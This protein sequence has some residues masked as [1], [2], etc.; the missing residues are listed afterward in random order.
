MKVKIPNYGWPMASAEEHYGGKMKETK[1]NMRNT[2]Y[3]N[4]IVNTVLLNH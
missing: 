4:H 3:I 1:K 2:H